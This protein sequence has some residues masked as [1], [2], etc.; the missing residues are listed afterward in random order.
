MSQY[1][2][3]EVALRILRSAKSIFLKYGYHR[4]SL[5]SICNQAKTS[6]S[7]LYNYYPNKDALFIAVLSPLL[8]DIEKVC[9]YGRSYQS[10]N[11]EFESLDDKKNNLAIALAYIKKHR[12]ELNLL[13]NLSFGSS[14]ENYSE[15]LS[16]EY[17]KNW[18]LFFDNLQ[19][20]CPDEKFKKPSSFFL[21]NM[22]HFHIMTVRKIISHQLSD[23]EMTTLTDE[24][25]I[26]FWHGGMGLI[27]NGI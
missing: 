1:K 3:D 5:R 13:F 22:A 21:R 14:L 26:F 27:K 2:K 16:Q 20:N 8:N 25:A 18:I 4:A 17:E 7:N 9:K 15:Y 19:K 12:S 23:D 6:L 24:L 10:K 11:T